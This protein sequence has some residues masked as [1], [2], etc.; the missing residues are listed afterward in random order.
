MRALAPHADNSSWAVGKSTSGPRSTRTR[1][2]A[3]DRRLNHQAGSD[4][5]GAAADRLTGDQGLFQAGNEP[6]RT[7]APARP[8]PPQ[9]VRAGTASGRSGQAGQRPVSGRSAAGQEPVSGRDGRGG[10][11]RR[12]AA[13]PGRARRAGRGAAAE[14]V[15]GHPAARQHGAPRAGDPQRPQ[16][17]SAAQAPDD[18]ADQDDGEPDAPGRP[19][20]P[21]MAARPRP[22]PGRCCWRGVRV[23]A[24]SGSRYRSMLGRSFSRASISPTV[25]AANALSSRS[26]NSSG[27]SRPA[28]RCSRSRDA[29]RSRSASDARIL[30]S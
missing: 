8:Q 14:R 17:A 25:L 30:G 3:G 20:G 7:T 10:R 11:R 9:P 13:D 22:P 1:P 21:G 27:V 26:L 23:S 5:P 6:R 12:A 19:P 2:S 15:R 24:A 16:V 29:V 4:I 28:V 18:E